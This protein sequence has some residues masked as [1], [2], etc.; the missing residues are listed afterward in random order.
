MVKFASDLGIWYYIIQIAVILTREAPPILTD[1]PIPLT[2][3]KRLTITSLHSILE[4][5]G[6]DDTRNALEEALKTKLTGYTFKSDNKFWE[7]NFESKGWYGLT[8]Q[9]RERYRD[10]YQRTYDHIFSENMDEKAMITL[11]Q[12][13]E[14]IYLKS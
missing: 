5:Y 1:L 4:P 8:T 7:V 3:E 11:F 10:E 2:Q 13:F 14:R 9:I 6:Y 12:S